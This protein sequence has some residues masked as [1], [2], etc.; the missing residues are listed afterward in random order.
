MGLLSLSFVLIAAF[1]WLYG[2][3]AN[4]TIPPSEQEVLEIGADAYI[5]GYP[6]VTMEITRRVMTNISKPDG[7]CAPLGQFALI[8]EYP[9]AAFWDVTAP[10]AGRVE[11]WHRC[12]VGSA[13]PLLPV[14][15][16]S[17]TE[18]EEGPVANK[19]ILTKLRH[20]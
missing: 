18:R 19:N 1:G 20:W 4:R 8:R 7:E 14:S 13:Y 16:G 3:S 17:A 12:S 10:T 11:G 2:Q 15:V 5:Y 9:T 6:L